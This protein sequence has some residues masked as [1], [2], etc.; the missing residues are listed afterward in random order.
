MAVTADQITVEITA[1][2][3]QY[4]RTMVQVAAVTSRNMAAVSPMPEINRQHRIRFA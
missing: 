3:D 4:E 2:Y 1:V